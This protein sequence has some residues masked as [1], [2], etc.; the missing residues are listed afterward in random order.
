MFTHIKEDEHECKK[1][2]VV[3]NNVAGDK[4]KY[5]NSNFF[6]QWNLYKT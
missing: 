2:K 6:F 5:K 4:V 3:N 1:T